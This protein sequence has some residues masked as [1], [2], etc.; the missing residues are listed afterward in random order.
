MISFSTIRD[1]VVALC[2]ATTGHRAYT[3]IGDSGIAMYLGLERGMTMLVPHDDG[4]ELEA[5]RMMGILWKIIPEAVDI[6]HIGSTAIRTIAAKPIIDIAV[7]LDDVRS[8]YEHIDVMAGYGL[9]HRGSDVPGQILFIMGEGNMRTHHIHIV[10]RDGAA[11]KNYVMFRD[12]LNLHP[13]KAA[14]YEKIKKRLSEAFP[15]N[16]R[17]YTEGKAGFIMQVLGEAGGFS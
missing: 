2:I 7:A 4:W 11:W 15:D 6:Q 3:L 13:D 1:G 17:A 12:H 10:E 5:K 9:I 16:R 14:E 8:V